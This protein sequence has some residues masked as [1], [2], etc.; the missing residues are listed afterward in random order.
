[1]LRVCAAASTLDL[2]LD[3]IL[4]TDRAAGLRV[5]IAD[6]CYHTG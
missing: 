3:T 2:M 5:R 1:M 6:G 4:R